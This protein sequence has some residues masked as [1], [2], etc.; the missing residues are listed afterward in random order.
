MYYKFV[1]HINADKKWK[2]RN[3][4]GILVGKPLQKCLPE[5]QEK[6]GRVVRVGGGWNWLNILFLWWF[7]KQMSEGPIDILGTFDMFGGVDIKCRLA[8]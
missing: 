5:N 4:K 3:K 1:K 7:K 6:T 8:T 2:R